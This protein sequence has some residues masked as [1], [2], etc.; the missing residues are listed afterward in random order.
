[1]KDDASDSW[2]IIYLYINE[3]L[4]VESRECVNKSSFNNCIFISETL[5]LTEQHSLRPEYS[6][7][8]AVVW[9]TSFRSELSG[10][11]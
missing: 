1:M 11:R 6:F 5:C 7:V 3:L 4:D 2:L 8:S 10:F 9:E